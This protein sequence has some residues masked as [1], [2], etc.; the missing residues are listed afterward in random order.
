ME[1]KRKGIILA[2]GFG[3]RLFPVTEV[4]SKQLLPVYDKPLIYYPLSILMLAD[5]RE[6]AIIVDPNQK[7]HFRELL[8]DGSQWGIKFTYI[9]QPYPDGIAQAFVLADKYLNGSPAALILGD[10]IFFGSGLQNLLKKACY[11]YKKN[12]I[13]THQVTNPKS[14]GVVGFNKKNEVD[15]IIEK[16]SNPKSNYVITG[17][18]FVDSTASIKASKLKRSKRGEFEITSLLEYYL[19]EKK[20]HVELLGRGFAWLD[21]GTH[22]S[23]LDASL[24][25]KTIQHRQN[26]L[27]GCPEE[28]AYANSWISK[29]RLKNIINKYRNNSYGKFLEKVLKKG[30]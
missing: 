15:S 28:I 6:I 23:L 27:I 1:N 24:F 2:G 12:T 3:T 25:I 4:V 8:K 5:I 29:E 13:F 11:N 26:I 19:K 14:F 7:K 17:L 9:E 21:T 18:Y 20:L 22:Q 10:N 16:P 30:F